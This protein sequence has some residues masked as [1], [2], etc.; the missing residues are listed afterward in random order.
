MSRLNSI[1]LFLILTCVTQTFANQKT[2]DAHPIFC[3][4]LKVKPSIKRKFAFELSN[5]FHNHIKLKGLDPLRAVAI[6]M[7]ESSFKKVT[8]YKDNKPLD[9]GL[10]QFHIDTIKN[11]GFDLE[12]LLNHDLEYSTKCYTKLMKSKLKV[13]KSL[14]DDAWTCYH[15]KNEGPRKRYKRLVNRFYVGEAEND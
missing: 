1:L 3:A 14:G 2:C 8:T 10:F 4:I 5:L 12:K 15:S 13:C 7:Q 11:Y 9:V 6:V